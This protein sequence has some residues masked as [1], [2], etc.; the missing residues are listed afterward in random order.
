MTLGF[1]ILLVGAALL[2]AGVSGRSFWALLKGDDRTASTVVGSS[3][4][5]EAKGGH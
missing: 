5:S 2:Y 3:L 1:A 4:T